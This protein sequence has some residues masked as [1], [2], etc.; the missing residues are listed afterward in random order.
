MVEGSL[1]FA[2]CGPSTESLQKVH[3][4]ETND[5]RHAVE[6]CGLE[7][8]PCEAEGNIASNC[9]SSIVP[10]YYGVYAAS[11]G[12]SPRDYAVCSLEDCGYYG[13]CDY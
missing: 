12:S 8:V 3:V 9:R 7:Y 10:S 2:K 6:N 11:G 4:P 5:D 1:A 13:H